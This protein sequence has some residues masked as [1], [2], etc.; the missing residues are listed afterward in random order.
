MS[1]RHG[2]QRLLIAANN[3]GLFVDGGGELERTGRLGRLGLAIREACSQRPRRRLGGVKEGLI[4]S[5][6]TPCGAAHGPAEW[7]RS[8]GALWD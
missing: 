1:R 2:H 5:C 3:L 7:C 4:R 8:Q 6:G